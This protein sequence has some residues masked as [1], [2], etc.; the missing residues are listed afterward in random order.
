MP[1][2]KRK[3]KYGNKKVEYD[4]YKFDSKLECKRYKE[5]KLLERAGVIRNIELQPR[6]VFPLRFI[7][8]E[9]KQGCHLSYKADFRYYD[10]ENKK[11]VVEDT[12]SKLVLQRDEAVKIRIA[13]V[14][15]F[16]DIKVRI[17][18]K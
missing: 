12:K 7:H 2:P 10:I 17:I 18:H 9:T 16:F 6:F 5:L 11:V 3:H 13:L 8:N 4:G 15:F 1:Y 14:Y